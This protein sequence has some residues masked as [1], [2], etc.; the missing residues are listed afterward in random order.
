MGICSSPAAAGRLERGLNKTN[1]LEDN[2]KAKQKNTGLARHIRAKP[3]YS[4]TEKP[5]A[6][7]RYVALLRFVSEIAAL[8]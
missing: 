7:R 2:C 6:S 8:Q 4:R 3:V 1:R 5:A